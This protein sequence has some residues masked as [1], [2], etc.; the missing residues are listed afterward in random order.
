MQ[1][2]VAF[3]TH[4]HRVG[5]EHAN[6][7]LREGAVQR[8]L[9]LA[10]DEV[11][12]VHAAATARLPATGTT[13]ACRAYAEVYKAHGKLD[14]EQE[15]HVVHAAATARFPAT[16]TTTTCHAYSKVYKGTRFFLSLTRASCMRMAGKKNETKT[17]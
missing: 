17:H 8:R 16:G 15:A 9:D 5:R 6:V 7:V 2:N 4:V 10:F 14:V 12:V 13:T 1:Q 11:H 3:D